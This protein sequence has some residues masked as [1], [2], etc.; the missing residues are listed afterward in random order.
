[1]LLVQAPHFNNGIPWTGFHGTGKRRTKRSTAVWQ[2]ARYK[3]ISSR[4]LL[5]PF[6]FL[7]ITCTFAITIPPTCSCSCSCCQL[8]HIAH[9]RQ[10]K[11][12]LITEYRLYYPT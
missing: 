6:M 1:M 5:F 7:L 4:S 10:F 11:F 8:L 3:A 2:Y 9:N 12:N